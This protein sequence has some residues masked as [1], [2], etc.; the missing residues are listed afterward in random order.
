[1]FGQRKFEKQP[2]KVGYFKQNG[3]KFQYTVYTRQ[4]NLPNSSKSIPFIWFFMI[5]RIYNSDTG[6]PVYT[7]HY[8]KEREYIVN[9]ASWITEILIP[10]RSL[11][12]PMTFCSIGRQCFVSCFKGTKKCFL[13][14]NK[15]IKIWLSLVF[16]IPA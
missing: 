2:C 3:W 8:R 10:D 9:T 14:P 13:F 6:F 15:Y 12:C 7:V 11:L 16:L 5:L 1:M 4:P